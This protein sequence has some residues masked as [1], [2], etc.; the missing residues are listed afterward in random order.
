MWSWLAVMMF[1]A[2]GALALAV[3]ATPLVGFG[4]LILVFLA[5]CG[6]MLLV[7]I[8]YHRRNRETFD[9]WNGTEHDE[10][11]AGR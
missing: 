2:F 5:L 7:M 9:A 1:V 6:V 10:S 8:G 11:R 3:L 4:S